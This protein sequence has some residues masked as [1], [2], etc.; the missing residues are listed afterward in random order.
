M[1]DP[2]NAE[3]ERFKAELEFVQGL[4]N[5]EYL[6]YLAQNRYF[7]DEDFVG[8][9]A[10]LRYWQELPFCTYLTFPHCL[11]MLELLQKPSFRSALKRADFKDELHAQQRWHWMY[12]AAP[13]CTEESRQQEAQ[14]AAAE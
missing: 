9:L 8:Y 11:R 5:P 14:E 1:P 3:E 2:E 12:R 13:P 4:A 6:H 7:D 10:Y